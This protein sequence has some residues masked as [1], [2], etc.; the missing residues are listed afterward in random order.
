MSTIQRKAGEDGSS[1]TTSSS[2]TSMMRRPRTGNGTGNAVWV[3]QG[4][5]G[6]QSSPEM[7]FGLADIVDVEDDE[8]A[9]PVADVEAI[10]DPHRVMAAMRGALPGRLLA[11][12]R[13]LPGHPPAA[14]LLGRGGF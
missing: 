5:G 8:A 3:G 6:L 7:N 10:A 14:D 2:A 1:R 9:V 13:P 4:N 11:A 12:G